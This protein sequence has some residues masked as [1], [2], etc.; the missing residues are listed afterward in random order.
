MNTIIIPV[1]AGIIAATVGAAA[2]IL[3]I[4]KKNKKIS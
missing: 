4:K 1:I 2:L 3:T